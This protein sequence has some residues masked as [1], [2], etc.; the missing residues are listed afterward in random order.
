[1]VALVGLDEVKGALPVSHSDD[2][3]QIAD[4][5]EAASE[6]VIGYLDTRAAAVIG[7]SEGGELPDMSTVPAAVRRAVIVCVQDM[8]DQPDEK[9]EVRGALPF[10]AERLL[11]RYAD[12]PCV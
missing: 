8:Y 5:I 12:P 1:M 3:A 2:D 11:Y 6:M 7:L 4:M 10:R 9:P